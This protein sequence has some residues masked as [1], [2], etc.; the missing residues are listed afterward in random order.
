MCCIIVNDI[1][2]R[3]ANYMMTTQWI[4]PFRDKYVGVERFSAQLTSGFYLM[5]TNED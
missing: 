2:N 5:I 1:V 4:F 3:E